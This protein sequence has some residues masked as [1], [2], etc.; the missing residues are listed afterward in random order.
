MPKL[1]LKETK[2]KIKSLRQKGYSLPE[3]KKEVS[4]SYGSI[5][6][7][8][9]GIKIL[10]KYLKTWHG[11]QGGSI[12]R[13]KNKLIEA[14]KKA[15]KSINYLSN[16]ERII[17]L[18]ALYWGEGSKSDFNI[19]NTDPNLIRVFIIGLRD[20]FGINQERLRVSIRIY[21]D[22]DKEKCLQYWSNITGVPVAQ[23]IS[24]NILKGKKKGKLPFGMCRIRISKGGDMLKYIK[25]V[26]KRISNKF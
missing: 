18:S 17:F 9:L 15:K 20:V 21:E 5:H 3:I 26:Y 13:K 7:Y 19:M 16:K 1:L 8:T 11:K 25:A 22:L 6:R 12:K 23:F 24:V 14:E 10:P 2:E 4:A